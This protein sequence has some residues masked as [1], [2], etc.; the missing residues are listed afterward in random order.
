M[1]VRVSMRSN[2]VL[3][4]VKSIIAPQLETVTCWKVRRVVDA[5]QP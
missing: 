2:N 4:Y 1:W 5:K 3:E